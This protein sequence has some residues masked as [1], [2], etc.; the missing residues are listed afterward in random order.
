MS[1][2]HSIQP[3]QI[4][5][6]T[7]NSASVPKNTQKRICHLCLEEYETLKG[8]LISHSFP[9]RFLIKK[10]AKSLSLTFSVLVEKLRIVIWHI[11]FEETT[12]VKNFLRL[13]QLL[14]FK[15]LQNHISTTHDMKH[16]TFSYYN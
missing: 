6:K 1:K 14:P 4:K 13:S 7:A 11:F 16:P 8:G 15:E 12:K 10:S 9:G 5:P 2:E 3:L